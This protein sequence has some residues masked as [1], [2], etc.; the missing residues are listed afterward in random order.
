M[1]RKRALWKLGGLWAGFLVLHYAYDF[2]PIFPLKLISG[3]NESFFQHAKIAFFAYL[4][5]N[6]VEFAIRRRAIQNGERFL[7]ARLLSTTLLPWFVFLTWYAA[8][9]FYGQLPS[10]FL[11]ILYANLALLAAGICTLIMEKSL[12][13]MSY[14]RGLKTV[15]L[16][17][18]V[19]SVFYYVIFTFRLP[20]T[21]FFA[22]PYAAAGRGRFTILK[23]RAKEAQEDG[24]DSGS[25]GNPTQHFQAREGQRMEPRHPL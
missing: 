18:F 3:T 1:D 8:A 15:V 10:V 22:D 20:W 14:S 12:E 19:L 9:A 7:F 13:T 25:D 2:V 21:D 11:E 6:G 4:V 17:L 16:A 24:D 5:V 23:K